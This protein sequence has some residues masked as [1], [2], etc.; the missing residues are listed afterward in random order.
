MTVP[1]SDF[2]Q[3]SM[4]LA[5]AA[6]KSS[7]WRAFVVQPGLLLAQRAVQLRQ[8]IRGA[9]RPQPF[10][11]LAR[12][13]HSTEHCRYK[14]AV[15]M[16]NRLVVV[17]NGPVGHAVVEQVVASGAEW[18]IH[19]FGEETRPAIS[20]DGMTIVGSGTNPDGLREAWVA[21][22]PEPATLSLLMLGCLTLLTRKRIA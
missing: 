6:R 17:G 8:A 14:R 9:A 22:I 1:V 12:G 10:L 5:L 21:T 7:S 18:E 2:P 15:Q 13:L 20:A 3:V 11:L 4:I 19:I 16:T